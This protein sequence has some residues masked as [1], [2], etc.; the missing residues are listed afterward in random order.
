MGF[1][2]RSAIITGGTRGIG[3]AVSLEL[4]RRGCNVAFNYLQSRKSADTLV[5]EINTAG[6]DAMSFQLDVS[7]LSSVQEMVGKVG[8]RFGT[9]DFLVNNAGI[10]RDTL[11]LRMKEKDW[12]DVLNT[13]LKGAFNFCRAV[14]ILT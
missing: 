3:R 7:D 11:I 4:A 10:I 6:Q 13:N 1:E 14:A 12:D 5:S 8:E 9:I 2:G